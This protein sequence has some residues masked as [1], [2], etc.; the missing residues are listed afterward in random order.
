LGLL[1]DVSGTDAVELGC[2]GAQFGI[3]LAQQRANVTDV[4]ISEEQLG[5]ALTI[6]LVYNFRQ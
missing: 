6:V 2:G 1:R 4:D 5:D 3:A